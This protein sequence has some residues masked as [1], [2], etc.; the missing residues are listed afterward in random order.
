MGD[1]GRNVGP[2]LGAVFGQAGRRVP[3]HFAVD[4]SLPQ[5]WIHLSGRG[6]GDQD[7][8]V[9]L[10]AIIPLEGGP[11]FALAGVGR[12][13]RDQRAARGQQRRPDRAQDFR[14][15]IG[16]TVVGLPKGDFVSHGGDA[17]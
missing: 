2:E 5:R 12:G 6:V 11:Q 17:R 9:P 4:I 1:K 15:R 3:V 10:S 7:A 16:R 8:W 13:N 14:I